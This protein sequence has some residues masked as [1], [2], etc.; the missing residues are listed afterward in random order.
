MDSPLPHIMEMMDDLDANS[1]E[2]VIGLLDRIEMRV[3]RLRKDAL[4][5]EEEK[6]TLITTIETLRNCDS[7]VSLEESRFLHR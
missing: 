4:R 5:L 6:D 1:K 2:K 7:V 3:E